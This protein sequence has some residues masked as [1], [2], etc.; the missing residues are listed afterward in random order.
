MVLSK[1][2]L[3][4]VHSILLLEIASETPLFFKCYDKK[5]TELLD[6]VKS[7]VPSSTTELSYFEVEGQRLPV[8][9]KGHQDL[10]LFVIGQPDTNE[11]ILQALADGLLEAMLSIY[12]P[13]CD[14]RAIQEAYEFLVLLISEAVHE[15]II[16]ESSGA[17]L[18]RRAS[19][20]RHGASLVDDLVE[21]GGS[22]GAALASAFAFAKER[23][24]GV[25]SSASGR[26]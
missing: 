11:L 17:E 20:G 16:M 22:G 6:H 4:P 5:V 7:L 14:S 2:A 24:K 9:C 18:A 23:F 26:H 13:I 1:T 19:H 15:G 12:K 25:L 21:G 8:L 3:R 10:R